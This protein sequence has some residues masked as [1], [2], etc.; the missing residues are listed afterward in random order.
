MPKLHQNYANKLRHKY[1]TITSTYAMATFLFKLRCTITPQIYATIAFPARDMSAT[2]SKMPVL[3][4]GFVGPRKL[5]Q[6]YAKCTPKLRNTYVNITPQLLH[7]YA[8]IAPKLRHH[9]S[10]HKVRHNYTNLCHG[11]MLATNKLTCLAYLCRDVRC[12]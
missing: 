4:P 2:H 1:D 3:T 11:V 12:V 8:N 6:Y 5:R 7:K 10:N 9:K